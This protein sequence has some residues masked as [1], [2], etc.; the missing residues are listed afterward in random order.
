MIEFVVL[1]FFTAVVVGGALYLHYTLPQKPTA[2]A[3]QPLTDAEAQKPISSL[4]RHGS[5]DIEKVIR[6]L[7]REFPGETKIAILAETILQKEGSK[8]PENKEIDRQIYVCKP[9]DARFFLCTMFFNL[10][11]EYFT[12]QNELMLIEDM[13]VEITAKAYDSATVDTLISELNKNA[14]IEDHD[15]YVNL[16]LDVKAAQKA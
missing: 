5:L 11:P 12:L 4:Y 3:P 1:L 10:L 2:K 8:N 15:H 7:E 16:L 9:T 6:L 14:Y 13:G